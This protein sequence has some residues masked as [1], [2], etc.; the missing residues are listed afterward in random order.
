MIGVRARRN[1]LPGRG[2]RGPSQ[3]VGCT[4]SE[5][6][7]LHLPTLG[8][9]LGCVQ[10]RI[11]G[12][13]QTA[14]RSKIK[15]KEGAAARG[16]CGAGLDSRPGGHQKVKKF[17]LTIVGSVVAA[18]FLAA[19]GSNP[20]AQPIDT[21]TLSP[22]EPSWASSYTP[23]QLADYNAALAAFGRIESREA[24]IWANPNRYTVTQVSRIFNGDWSNTARPI[25]QFRAYVSNDIRV[26]GVPKVVSSRPGK[27]ASNSGGS[28]LEQI[29]I[30]QCVDGSTVTATQRGAPL[31]SGGADRGI[32]V[33]EMFKT[34]G[35]KY[36]LFQVGEGDGSC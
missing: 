11:R 34:V 30:R 7:W 23:A 12:C 26:S 36:L 2:D 25:H 15:E 3:R 16:V 35:G 6:N 33:V 10:C 4:S 28:G 27:I 20:R 1:V 8:L 9:A 19:C 18:L 22:T 31:K 24:P 32:R 29:T 5:V 17:A 14:L 13:P 21:P